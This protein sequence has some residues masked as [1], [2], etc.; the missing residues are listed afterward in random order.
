MGESLLVYVNLYGFV[1]CECGMW[2][3]I[4]LL[5]IVGDEVGM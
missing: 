4:L 2:Y 5:L 1:G 3:L